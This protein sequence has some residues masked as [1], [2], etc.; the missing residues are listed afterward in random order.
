M[1]I[2][3]RNSLLARTHLTVADAACYPWGKSEIVV[4]D[5][6][7]FSI[8]ALVIPNRMLWICST[9]HLLRNTSLPVAVVVR[10]R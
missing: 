4:M 6:D 5:L 1:K 3:A 9:R 8:I 2:A 7:W 10:L